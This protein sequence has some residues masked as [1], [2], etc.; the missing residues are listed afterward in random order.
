MENL[1]KLC[2][3]QSMK[4]GRP[5]LNWVV[6][7]DAESWDPKNLIYPAAIRWALKMATIDGGHYPERLAKMLI[8]NAPRVVHT[9]Y[10]MLNYVLDPATRAKIRIFGPDRAQWL[11]ELHEL[12]DPD[13]LPPEYGGTGA[14]RLRETLSRPP[15]AGGKPLAYG[16]PD[17]PAGWQGWAVGVPGQDLHEHLCCCLSRGVEAADLKGAR[18]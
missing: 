6:L 9:F 13:Q 7:I 10:E 18:T 11:P 15:S 2:G 17:G 12:V 8:V 1:V 3:E 5:V 4:L 16:V 14:C